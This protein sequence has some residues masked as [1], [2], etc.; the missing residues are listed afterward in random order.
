MNKAILFKKI[1]A[2]N[3]K[4]Q[5]S[6]IPQIPVV[7]KELKCDKIIQP[8]IKYF[9][10][11]YDYKVTFENKDYQ[12]PVNLTKLFFTFTIN[13]IEKSRI[14]FLSTGH[15][16]AESSYKTELNNRIHKTSIQQIFVDS[17]VFYSM[18]DEF[19]D[20]CLIAF[21]NSLNIQRDNYLLFN[22]TNYLI[23]SVCRNMD[24]KF[25]E[26]EILIKNGFNT[27]ETR[28]KPVINFQNDVYLISKKNNYTYYTFKIN[29]KIVIINTKF[30][31]GLVVKTET[32]SISK[33]NNEPITD[34]KHNELLEYYFINSIK[35]FRYHELFQAI[36]LNL[37][38]IKKYYIKYKETNCLTVTSMMGD[39]GC[40]FF[41]LIPD[42][43]LEF[44]GINIGGCPMIIL[45]EIKL[46]NNIINWSNEKEKLVFGKY[47]IEQVHRAGQV[48]PINQ[49]EQLI[50]SCLPL[51]IKITEIGV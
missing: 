5:D 25:L 30:A 26:N 51:N 4:N 36:D 10:G 24:I 13:G 21:D 2:A 16:F 22:K 38:N 32:S 14:L 40:G 1:A 8:G 35:E 20:F 42:N 46:T 41:R 44:V 39:S 47:V 37:D 18:D 29:G 17:N 3:I 49:I 43:N 50:N 19:N 9:S 27:G 15:S 31:S 45:S 11:P 12:H 34:I 7:E 23:N 48:L 33:F 28:T 6:I